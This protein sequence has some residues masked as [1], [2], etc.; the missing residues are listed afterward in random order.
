MDWTRTT[1]DMS[2]GQGEKLQITCVPWRINNTHT[3]SSLFCQRQHADCWQL[4]IFIL[5]DTS[6]EIISLLIFIEMANEMGQ[7]HNFSGNNSQ[8][9]SKRALT[10]SPLVYSSSL[11]FYHR[12]SS[13]IGQSTLPFFKWFY[14]RFSAALCY[15]EVIF[16][17]NL[18]H[19]FLLSQNV[20]Y[21]IN[22]IWPFKGRIK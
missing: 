15:V 13:E 4:H 17:S 22:L 7:P 10:T 20:L 5:F 8:L 16:I 2:F 3:Q 14:S 12:D 9:N 21:V 18:V 1:C 11:L 19:S 6:F